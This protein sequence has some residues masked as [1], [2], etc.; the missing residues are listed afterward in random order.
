[1]A[2]NQN[3]SPGVVSLMTIPSPSDQLAT[4]SSQSHVIISV[5]EDIA[6]LLADPESKL[7]P[8]FDVCFV[9]FI[10][11]AF[12]KQFPIEYRTRANFCETETHSHV[13]LLDTECPTLTVGTYNLTGRYVD[14]VGSDLVFDPSRSG[15]HAGFVAS[16]TTR[17]L[18]EH[19]WS[20]CKKR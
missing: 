20:N 16:S 9:S 13:Q 11:N 15:P 14:V 8:S 2:S 4:P 7:T 17:I 3:I 6:K 5:P 10:R 12:L 19:N 1:M 18:F